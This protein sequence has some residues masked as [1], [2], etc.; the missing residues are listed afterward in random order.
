MKLNKFYPACFIPVLL[1]FNISCNST[2]SEAD[3]L[4]AKVVSFQTAVTG[5]DNNALK[6]LISAETNDYS[7]LQ[8]G[9]YFTGAGNIFAQYTF[10]Y[11]NIQPTISGTTATVTARVTATTRSDGLPVS[12]PITATFS[13]KQ[14][15]GGWFITQL[16]QVQTSAGSEQVLLDNL[17]EEELALLDILEVNNGTILY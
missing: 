5:Q 8:A 13:F 9:T 7:I 11:S 15:S 3:T 4:A 6:A 1:L 10:V 12:F 2:P 17:R 16:T 14:E